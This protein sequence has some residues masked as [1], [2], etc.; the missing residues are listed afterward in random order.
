MV[1]KTK[2]KNEYGYYC[3]LCGEKICKYALDFRDAGG[4]VI[5]R[6]F[7]KSKDVVDHKE[8]EICPEC[9][10]EIAEGVVDAF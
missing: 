9:S 6:A 4:L 3:D 1:K 7:R 10:K 5:L 2:P 8:F